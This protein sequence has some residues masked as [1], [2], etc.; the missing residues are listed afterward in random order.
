MQDTQ[1]ISLCD[2]NLRLLDNYTDI[3]KTQSFFIFF[4]QGTTAPIL[5]YS[6]FYF[7][8]SLIERDIVANNFKYLFSFTMEGAP[9]AVFKYA[10][11]QEFLT[12]QI[13]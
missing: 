8:N 3:C 6:Y 12:K 10:A 1:Y 2:N 4:I 5:L 9:G 7:V 11:W 13:L